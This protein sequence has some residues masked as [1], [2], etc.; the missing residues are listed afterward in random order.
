MGQDHSGQGTPQRLQ[1]HGTQ[2]LAT[3]GDC[4]GKTAE[5]IKTWVSL[6]IV[7]DCPSK[8]NMGG[9]SD[10]GRSCWSLWETVQARQTGNIIM[11]WDCAVGHS[12]RLSGKTNKGGYSDIGLCCRSL[13]ETVQARQT[14]EVI[15]TSDCVVGHCGRLA[16]QTGEVI[17]T[18][19]CVVGH[20]G[21]LSRHEK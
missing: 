19:D 5:V 15:V 13:W 14:G 4:P 16:R 20:C 11:T 2:L 6:V 7:G 3:V 1:R 18:S 17:A 21:R 12:R 8:T 10:M 9:Y